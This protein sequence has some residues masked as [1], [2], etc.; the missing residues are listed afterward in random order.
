MGA[1]FIAFGCVVIAGHI[2]DF[3]GLEDAIRKGSLK[4]I[5]ESVTALLWFMLFGPFWFVGWAFVL[6]QIG[7]I[8]GL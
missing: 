1:I 8:F 3:L 5:K 4:P 2:I 6:W 7:V